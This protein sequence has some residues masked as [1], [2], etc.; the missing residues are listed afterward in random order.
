MG[1]FLTVSLKLSAFLKVIIPENDIKN[2][3]SIACSKVQLNFA[4]MIS[5]VL[6]DENKETML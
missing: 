6:T 4:G 5:I 3:K 2:P 1:T